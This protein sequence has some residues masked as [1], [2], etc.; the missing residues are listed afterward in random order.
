MP[1]STY[2]RN[3]KSKYVDADIII[4]GAGISGINSAHHIHKDFPELNYTILDRRDNLGGT[5][6]LFQYPG[7]RSDSDL[8]TF[9]FKWRPWPEAR[10]IVD[11]PSIVKYLH[12]CAGSE[13]IDRHIR[14]GHKV[15]HADWS[16]TD[17]LWTLTVDERGQQKKMRCHFVVMGTGYY[18]YDKPLE[19]VI[20]GIENFSGPKIHPQF[21][22][23]DLDYTD[24]NI[25]VIGSGATAITLLP[26]L[27]KESAQS[28]A[29]A[30]VTMLQRSPSY[31]LPQKTTHP[32]EKLIHAIFPRPFALAI[33]RWKYILISVLFFNFCH[34]FPNAARKLLNAATKKNLPP[35][36]KMDPDWLPRYTPWQQRLCVSPDADFYDAIKDGRT[37]VMTGV[38]D[39]I[40][41]KSIHLADGRVLNPDIIITA[42]G[43]KLCM[44]GQATLTVD[45]KSL[46]MN[47]HFIWKGMA[48]DG[49]PNAAF[50]MGYVNASWTLGAEA[51]GITLVK[52]LK[53]M[54]EKRADVVLPYIQGDKRSLMKAAKPP[55]NLTSTY[56]QAAVHAL[57]MSAGVGP[58]KGRSSVFSDMWDAKF[59]NVTD[60]MVY[61]KG[62]DWLNAH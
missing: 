45:G 43:L 50:T 31:I 28:G 49:V 20:P 10:A 24:K 54:K 16:S 2:Y 44:M 11:G 34:V 23:K 61:S 55:F 36:T 26:A 32:D 46:E 59:G 8:H 53:K 17:S 29:A 51:M 19:A 25:V 39:N 35:G 18:N 13:G 15:L 4:V 48:I 41:E 30:H 12:D 47:K 27:V 56:L 58:W 6:D 33:V 37:S 14:Y 40:T 22:P 62:E 3:E 9:G 38:I 21:W 60:D 1:S 42:T 5:W 52:L 7:I 57:P